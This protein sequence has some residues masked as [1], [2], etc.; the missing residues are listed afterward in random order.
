MALDEIPQRPDIPIEKARARLQS[1]FD[2]TPEGHA[3]GWDTLWQENFIPWDRRAPNP[4]L[5]DALVQ[6]ADLLGTPTTSGKGAAEGDDGAK[7][8]RKR[9]LVPGCGRGYDV[10]LLA[11]HGW[12]AVGLEVSAEAVKSAEAIREPIEGGKVTGYAAVDKELGKGEARFVVGDFFK[13]DWLKEIGAEAEEA[14][15]LI[16]D[17]TVS[18]SPL[19]SL[20]DGVWSFW[21]SHADVACDSS[22]APSPSSCV[23]VGRRPWRTC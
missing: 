7:K 6:K 3:R 21:I 12:D 16:Y 20:Q 1:V 18:S 9:A 8:A 11:A 23:R 10:Y 19:S 13:D 22:C 4:A 5:E 14:F 17:Y 15:D 2:G